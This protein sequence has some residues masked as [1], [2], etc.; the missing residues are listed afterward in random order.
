MTVRWLSTDSSSIGLLKVMLT[1]PPPL[2]GSVLTTRGTPTVVNVQRF[3][4]VIVALALKAT[5][6]GFTTASKAVSRGRTCAGRN[7]KVWSSGH[8]KPPVTGL[9][10]PVGASAKLA[11]AEAWST[12]WLNCTVM[13]GCGATN[14]LLSAGKTAATPGDSVV[15]V[16]G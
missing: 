7:T 15:K 11:S 1:P 2:A 5:V 12:G 6:P 3:S 14:M 10:T 13:S 4:P 8:W 9:S 16:K